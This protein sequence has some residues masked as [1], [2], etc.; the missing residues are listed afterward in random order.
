MANSNMAAPHRQAFK[1]RAITRIRLLMPKCSLIFRTLHTM[2]KVS[3][4]KVSFTYF[5]PVNAGVLLT[6]T[7]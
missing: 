5:K 6:L 7:V 3:L 1:P 4:F 2:F